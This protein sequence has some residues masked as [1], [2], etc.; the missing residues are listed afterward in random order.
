[1]ACHIGVHDD[2]MPYL[3]SFTVFT[4]CCYSTNS[5]STHLM[6]NQQTLNT[7]C[8]DYSYTFQV[9]QMH[10]DLH[11]F[12]IAMTF[13]C[14]VGVVGHVL[15]LST[16]HKN[17]DLK[18]QCYLL[19]AGQ[20]LTDLLFLLQHGF[21]EITVLLT[22]SAPYTRQNFNPTTSLMEPT[23]ACQAE[24]FFI[25]LMCS[26]TLFASALV[27]YDRFTT[28]C[29]DTKKITWRRAKLSYFSIWIYSFCTCIIIGATGGGYTTAAFDLYCCPDFF[30]I[31]SVVLC[32]VLIFIPSLSL[33]LFF[34]GRVVLFLV[35]Y[36]GKHRREEKKKKKKKKVKISP[37]R[38]SDSGRESAQRREQKIKDTAP[39]ISESQVSGGG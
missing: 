1:M 16:I 4:E 24:G 15:L 25:T 37:T 2:F 13:L 5:N 32:F 8:E 36:F 28:I 30:N 18:T 23:L 26:T 34:Y 31:A 12:Y 11:L 10:E 35:A 17:K 20:L 39:I 9:S 33:C 27:A 6:G 21:A 14:A 22:G 19:V 29:P 7:L 38:E 3:E